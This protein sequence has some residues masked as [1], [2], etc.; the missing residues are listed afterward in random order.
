MHKLLQQ[1]STVREYITIQSCLAEEMLLQLLISKCMPLFFLV[2]L[3]S[4]PLTAFYNIL[5][6]IAIFVT[7]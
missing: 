3:D 7:V 5:E 1:S 2:S 4:F 6:Q